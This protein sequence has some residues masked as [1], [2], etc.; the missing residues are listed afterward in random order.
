M[1]ITLSLIWLALVVSPR[2]L[3]AQPSF[4][5]KANYTKSEHLIAM[6]DGVKLFVSVYVPKDTSQK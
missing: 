3:H 1:R 2:P 5:V 4:D 6:R